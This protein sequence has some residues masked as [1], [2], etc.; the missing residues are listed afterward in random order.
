M[1]SFAMETWKT[2]CLCT[3]PWING[4]ETWVIKNKIPIKPKDSKTTQTTK[5]NK[6]WVIWAH[7]IFIFCS[8]T[9]MGV[10]VI[11]VIVVT[12]LFFEYLVFKIQFLIFLMLCFLCFMFFLYCSWM[13]WPR[14]NREQLKLH[15]CGKQET[16]GGKITVRKM[17]KRCQMQGVLPGRKRDRLFSVFDAPAVWCASPFQDEVC[18]L[19]LSVTNTKIAFILLMNIYYFFSLRKIFHHNCELSS[20]EEVV[21]V[22]CARVSIGRFVL[23]VKFW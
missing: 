17:L 2:F 21:T 9:V 3:L 8:E 6:N 20:P 7:E 4:H 12:N 10:T 18:F 19:F 16:V 14:F 13:A 23:V 22:K 5:P 11:T 1:Q 15:T